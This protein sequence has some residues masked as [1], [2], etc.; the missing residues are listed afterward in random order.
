MRPIRT[1]AAHRGRH[2]R[3]ALALGLTLLGAGSALSCADDEAAGPSAWIDD[4]ANLQPA[5]RI[6][7]VDDVSERVAALSPENAGRRL[8]GRAGT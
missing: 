7:V 1:A 6:I 4:A 3:A 2:G 8:R 5:G